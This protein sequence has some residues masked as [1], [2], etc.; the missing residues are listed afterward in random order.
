MM[1]MRRST[2]S[3]SSTG[4]SPAQQS[5]LDAD[6]VREGWLRKKG[7]LFATIKSRYFVLYADGHLVYLNDVKKKKQKGSVVLAMSDIVAPHPTK[8]NDKVRASV[9]P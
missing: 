2:S 9:N 3:L 5:M 7:H 1:F 6:I 8:K 4:S